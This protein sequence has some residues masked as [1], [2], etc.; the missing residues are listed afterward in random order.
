MISR[1]IFQTFYVLILFFFLMIRRPPRS[2]RT[3]TLFPYTTL[4]RS[5]LSETGAGPGEIIQFGV[6]RFT[7][8]EKIGGGKG[9]E[10]GHDHEMAFRIVEIIANA[11]RIKQ[12]DRPLLIPQI[13]GMLEGQVEESPVSGCHRLIG[14]AIDGKPG[15]AQRHPVGCK[16][17]RR[18]AVDI[19][20]ELVEHNDSRKPAFRRLSP[21]LDISP[22][23]RQVGFGKTPADIL[24]DRIGTGK[25]LL[26]R[27]LREPEIQNGLMVGALHHHV[28]S[29]GSPS[30]PGFCSR[31]RQRASTTILWSS[32]C[33]RPETVTAPT[34]PVPSTR[35]RKLPP[36]VA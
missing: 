17:Q 30:L 1:L 13:F 23:K 25:P 28:S 29:P 16:R 24:V 10:V 3:D 14:T 15:F 2:T 20:R 11:E 4:F 19:A 27:Q 8:N 12:P 31:I 34:P 32:R 5:G 22:G 33:G 9:A 18:A 35:I 26:A 7:A 21:R 6:G 36:S